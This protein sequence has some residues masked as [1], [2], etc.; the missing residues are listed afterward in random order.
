VIERLVQGPRPGARAVVFD[1][2]GTVGMVRAGWMPMMLDMMMETLGPLGGSRA[3]AEAYVA[4]FTGQ[5]TVRQMEP[6]EDH[7][8]RL[9]GHPRTAPEYKAEFME[10]LGLLRT[11]RLRA[12]ELD[13]MPPDDLLVRGVRAFLE[14]LQNRD[15]E[16]YLASGSAHD[17]ILHETA[18]LNI[19]AYFRGI[20]GS[21]PLSLTKR[22]LMER[23]VD[24]GI[25]GDEIYVFGDGRTE[26]EEAKRVGGWG[27]AVAS[28]EPECLLVDEKKRTWL[29]DAGADFVVP[30]YEQPG[31]LELTVNGQ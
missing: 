9:G 7:V 5:D 24:S 11:A 17:E 16:I 15:I 30:N 12:V 4:H 6:F 20:Y 1:F 2:D 26:I 14:S 18:L 27:I 10:R 13:E 21:S 31:L 28:D 29:I 25:R 19:A 23:I 8:A 3:E 22:A